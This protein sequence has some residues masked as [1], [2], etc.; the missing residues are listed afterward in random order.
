MNSDDQDLTG[1]LQAELPGMAA[2]P[3]IARATAPVV[4]LIADGRRR[5]RRRQIAIGAG[6]IV[7]MAGVAVAAPQ[8]LGSAGG[9]RTS[10]A[11]AS[12]T[13]GPTAT[14]SVTSASPTAAT[15]PSNKVTW[16]PNPTAPRSGPATAAIGIAYPFDLLTHCD[17]RYAHFDGRWWQTDH[18]VPEPKPKPDPES[19]ITSYNGYTAGFM[20]LVS[21]DTARFDDPG[22]VTV[23]FHPMA[24]QPLPCA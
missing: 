5:K 23:T 21:A 22:V 4:K 9:S 2:D 11:P 15:T 20:T 18:T 1:L 10:A 19:G 3:A 7:A 14:G 16:T 8:I 6:T 24:G 13:P 12:S 17:I